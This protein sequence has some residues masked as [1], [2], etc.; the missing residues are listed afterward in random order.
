METITFSGGPGNN[1]EEAVV[2]NGGV[3]LSEILEAEIDYLLAMHS[4]KDQQI[5]NI[6]MYFFS[7]GN[8]NFNELI[9]STKKALLSPVILNINLSAAK[10]D[11]EAASFI[12][13][14]HSYLIN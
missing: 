5:K 6:D 9:L 8:L 4:I 7:V 12:M 2:V 10:I 3:T 13:Q 11:N 14:H 1:I